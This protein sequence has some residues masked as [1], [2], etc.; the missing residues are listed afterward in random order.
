MGIGYL[1][2]KQNK[3]KGL[4]N[5]DSISYGIGMRAFLVVDVILR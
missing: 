5:F 2:K 3:N 1:Q 4:G